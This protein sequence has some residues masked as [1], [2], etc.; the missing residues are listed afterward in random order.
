[1]G[2]TDDELFLMGVV[3]LVLTVIM[4]VAKMNKASM[5]MVL[6]ALVLMA[7]A[8]ITEGH[9]KEGY[10][11]DQLE[12]HFMVL[13]IVDTKKDS[14]HWDECPATWEDFQNWKKNH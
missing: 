5:V 12:H 7:A 10:T 6:I 9:P 3:A 13:D 14:S 4:V 8:L 11:A 2:L 1:M